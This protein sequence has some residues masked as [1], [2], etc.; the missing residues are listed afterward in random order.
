MLLQMALFHFILWLSSVPLYILTHSYVL[1][2]T[3]QLGPLPQ[4][5]I[6]NFQILVEYVL[7]QPSPIGRIV[8][9]SKFIG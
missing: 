6:L 7:G 5:I 3:L 8:P 9:P 1:Q 4:V 2:I